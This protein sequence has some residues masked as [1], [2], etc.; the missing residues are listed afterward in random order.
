MQ[1]HHTHQMNKLYTYKFNINDTKHH[2]TLL[3]YCYQLNLVKETN[4]LFTL[5]S[6]TSA[7]PPTENRKNLRFKARAIEQPILVF[8]TTGGPERQIMFP[9][10]QNIR[11]IR[12]H[13]KTFW[14]RP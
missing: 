6:A 2:N 14:R 10:Y 13:V 1:C 3:Y 5:I 4:I 9:T 8:P 11:K 7:N 12:N